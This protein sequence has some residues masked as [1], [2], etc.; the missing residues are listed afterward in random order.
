MRGSFHGMGIDT[1]IE[2]ADAQLDVDSSSNIDDDKSSSFGDIS[3][4]GDYSS[5][6][7]TDPSAS[8]GTNGESSM[9]NNAAMGKNEEKNVLRSKML[10][11]IVL[12]LAAAGMGYAVYHFLKADETNDF[13]VQVSFF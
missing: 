9:L 12:A 2:R 11:Y 7:S 1:E 3:H 5:E 6:S 8:S 10:V 4:R 13:E